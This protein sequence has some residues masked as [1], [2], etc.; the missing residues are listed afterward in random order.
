MHVSLNCYT[1]LTG[2]KY[3]VDQ[4]MMFVASKHVLQIKKCRNLVVR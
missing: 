1:A 2:F 4:A 3:H